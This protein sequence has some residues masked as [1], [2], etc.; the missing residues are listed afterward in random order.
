MHGERLDPARPILLLG[1]LACSVLAHVLGVMVLRPWLRSL[2]RDLDAPPIRVT[3][4]DGDV[5]EQMPPEQR[6]ALR[7]LEATLAPPTPEVVQEPEPPAP[8]PPALP[9][10]QVVEIAPPEKQRAPVR[11]EYL[12]EHDAAVQEETRTD[13][14]KVNPD[15]LTNRYS[16][17][18]KL[19]LEER[20]DV[21]A[22]EMSTGATVG[23]LATPAPGVGA[24]ASA[25]V[26]PWTRTNKEGLAAP[27]PASTSSQDIAG[28]PQNDR[29]AER[30]GEVLALNT[31]A[32]VGAAYINRIKRQVNAHWTMEL[33]NLSPSTRLARPRYETVVAIVLDGKGALERIEVS[34]PSGSPDLDACVVRAFH[35]AGPFPN[36]PSQLIGDDGKIHLDR[37]AF[38]V[39]LGRAKMQYGGID[40][41]AGV[42]FPGIQKSPR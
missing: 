21:G 12:A 1:I 41:R 22:T 6:E 25:V 19:A 32:F 23:S 38:E 40:P 29:L 26:S 17:D 7:R 18:S 36:P 10:G 8:P 42:Q 4:I 20:I 14:V 30:R 5:T 11:A 27:V 9:S 35:L 37:L 2:D 16:E 13:R 33:D 31:R 24:P 15:V 34:H 39:V 28:A 3:M